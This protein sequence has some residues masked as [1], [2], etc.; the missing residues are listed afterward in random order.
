VRQ[1]FGTAASASLRT[2]WSECEAPIASTK[3]AGSFFGALPSLEISTVRA[4]VRAASAAKQRS[5]TAAF[6]RFSAGAF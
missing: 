6:S 2:A 5:T 3:M 4:T 1:T